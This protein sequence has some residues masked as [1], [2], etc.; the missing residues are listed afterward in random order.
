MTKS[1]WQ[2]LLQAAGVLLGVALLIFV[3]LRVVPGNPVA[4][5]MGEHADKA[6]I[7]RM[8]AEL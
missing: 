7:D 6:T 2:R 4:V 1:I 3:M 5:M 8:T